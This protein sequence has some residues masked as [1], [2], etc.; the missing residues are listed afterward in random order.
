MRLKELFESTS[1]DMKTLYCSRKLLNGED[2]VKWAKGQGFDKCLDPKEM[3]VTIAYSKKPIDWSD[4][5]DSFDHVQSTV[6]K[7]PETREIKLFGKDKNAVV[8][9][10]EN[11]DLRRRWEEFRDDF[12]ASWDHDGY[13]PHIS[14][15][16]DGLP[17]GLE[18]EDIE[19]YTGILEFG[20]EI[21]EPVKSDWGSKVKEIKLAA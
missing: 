2:L 6:K 1:K 10:F 18:L 3:H 11:D 8:L 21:M 19:P 4:M 14:I 5:T 17:E 9:A 15:T 16:Y 12:G 20:P 13:H 7:H